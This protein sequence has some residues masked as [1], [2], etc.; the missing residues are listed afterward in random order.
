[1]EQ[2]KL[3]VVTQSRETGAK[4]ESL[5]IQVQ[6]R[7]SH[8]DSPPNTLD[9]GPGT[10]IEINF[11]KFREGGDHNPREILKKSTCILK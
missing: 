9:H 11:V 5:N 4:L 3:D 1:M 8:V 7:V 10:N 2:M 6:E